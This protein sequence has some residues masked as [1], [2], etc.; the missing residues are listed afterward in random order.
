MLPALVILSLA[1][2]TTAHVAAWAPG[3]YCKGGNDTSKD[4]PNTNLAVNPLYM[5]TK[6]DWWFQH[7]RG[8]DEAPPPA[9]EFL[10]LP[11]GGSFDVELAHNRAFTTLSYPN[12]PKGAWPDGKEHPEDWQGTVKNGERCLNNNPDGEGGAMHTGNQ[13]MAAGTAFAI[14]YESEL[15]KVTMDNL[16]VFTTLEQ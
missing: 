10:E 12:K 4:D 15:S 6:K 14:S 13:S 16:V 1:S 3:M 11:A 7:H 2:L 8:C 9:N 5:K